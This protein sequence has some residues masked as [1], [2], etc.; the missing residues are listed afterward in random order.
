MKIFWLK[1]KCFIEIHINPTLIW[2]KPDSRPL[3]FFH[4]FFILSSCENIILACKQTIKRKSRVQGCLKSD[5]IC[6]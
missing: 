1:K 6:N 2:D 5:L 3:V 4:I